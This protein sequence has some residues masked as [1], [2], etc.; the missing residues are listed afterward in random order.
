MGK[1][2]TSRKPKASSA[3][4]M[5]FVKLKP[6][7]KTKP[8]DPDAKLRD[9]QFIARAL[10][11]AMLDDDLSAFREIVL[12]HYESK[13]TAAALKKA[14]LSPRTFYAAL[15]ENGN[16]GFHTLSKIFR[17]MDLDQILKRTA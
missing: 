4:E 10:L 2:K 17:G 7:V 12:A 5:P 11:Q 8:H 15:K 9:P 16:P 14:A 6:G 13:N 3:S 1:A